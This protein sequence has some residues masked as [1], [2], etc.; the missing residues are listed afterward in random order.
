M[1]RLKVIYKEQKGQDKKFD[2]IIG[3]CNGVTVYDPFP[4]A[5]LRVSEVEKLQDIYLT[6]IMKW[7]M[8]TVEPMVFN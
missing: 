3:T 1:I 6:E 8:V 4:I 2:R 7:V 5:Y